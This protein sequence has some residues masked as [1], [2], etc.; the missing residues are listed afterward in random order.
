MDWDARDPIP[1]ERSYV[2]SQGRLGLLEKALV[3]QK[4]VRRSLLDH[5]HRTLSRAARLKIPDP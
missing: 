2:P 5:N 1:V 4:S 3:D